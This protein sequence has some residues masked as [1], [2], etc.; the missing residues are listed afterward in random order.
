MSIKWSIAYINI[1]IIY[2]GWTQD[3][4]W[5]GVQSIGASSATASYPPFS[6]R[7]FQSLERVEKQSPQYQGNDGPS[8][9]AF[10][11]EGSTVT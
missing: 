4:F 2:L 10:F 5:K 11:H 8:R 6:K 3:G 9:D 7:L 1:I